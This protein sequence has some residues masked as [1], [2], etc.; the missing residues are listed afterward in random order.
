[1]HP[2]LNKSLQFGAGFFLFAISIIPQKFLKLVELAGFKADRDAGLYYIKECHKNGGIRGPYS[3][4]TLLFNNLLLPRGLANADS[5]LQEADTLIKESLEKFPNG[6]LF[7]VMGSHCARKQ[8]NID[9]GIEL[10]E[11]ALQNSKH[12]KHP[13]LIYRY[14]LANCFCMKLEWQKAAELYLTLI[15]EP[16]F[17]VRIFCCMQLGACY[18]MLNQKEKAISVFN[19]ALGFSGKKSHFDPI[20][21]RQIKRYLANGG[22]FAA[23]E[24]L[25][26]RR[27]LAK[28]IPIMPTVLKALEETAAKT[29]A[30]EQ[31]VPPKTTQA[32]KASKGLSFGGFKQLAS[33]TLNSM[34]KKEVTDFSADD[35][36]SYLL[37]KGTMVKAL[38]KQEE[39]ILCF[40]E[41]LS[42]QEHINEKLYVP[43]CLYE[44]GECY[45]I[46]GQTSEAQDMMKRCSKIG[47]YDWED[48]LKI[49]LKVTMDQLKKGKLPLSEQNKFI[50]IEAMV[51]NGTDDDKELVEPG[52]D[53]EA[54]ECDEKKI[55]EVQESDDEE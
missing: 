22:Q 23:F 48:P 10:M 42:M 27:D 46:K 51:G 35:R 24:L 3:T 18:L 7:H 30:L 49:R 55:K 31:F 6:S 43:Y 19:K 28:M 25:Y 17:Q 29:K 50:S 15:D 9:K 38:G 47:N 2:E 53:D 52:S 54:D 14:E 13:P 20:V 33:S 41:V 32:P 1:M 4:M 39:A 12:F 34:K 37:L 11:L 8:C 21:L 36:A 26:L 16:K 45:Y 40:K 44:I 5:Y